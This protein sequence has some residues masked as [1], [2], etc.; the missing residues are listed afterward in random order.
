MLVRK[1]A[2]VRAREVRTP[3]SGDSRA[4]LCAGEAPPL[5]S[6]PLLSPFV[7]L[8]SPFWP[9][10]K[11]TCKQTL[12]RDATSDARRRLERRIIGGAPLGMRGGNDLLSSAG[13]GAGLSSTTSVWIRCFELSDKENR[14]R[15][16]IEVGPSENAMTMIRCPYGEIILNRRMF[17][18]PQYSQSPSA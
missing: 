16:E 4:S 2:V 3:G 18:S 14:R 5:L 6:F 7:S 13:R 11:R 17:S 12:T 9:D 10:F 8:V 1:A 15:S